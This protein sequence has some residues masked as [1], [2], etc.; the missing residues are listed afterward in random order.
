[1]LRMPAT[2]FTQATR[3]GTKPKSFQNASLSCGMPLPAASRQNEFSSQPIS[4]EE[5][6]MIARLPIRK[7][8]I[9][10]WESPTS[11]SR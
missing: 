4:K 9:D 1:M 10:W 5:M 7:V 3:H 6:T 11:P 8:D 2:N